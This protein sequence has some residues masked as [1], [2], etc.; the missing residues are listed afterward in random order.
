MTRAIAILAVALLA[1]GCITRH[2]HLEFYG[3]API[4]IS[5]SGEVA[6]DSTVA[7]KGSVPVSL[8]SAQPTREITP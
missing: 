1:G 2:Y 5:V 7:P 4:T 6:S 3:D 8:K